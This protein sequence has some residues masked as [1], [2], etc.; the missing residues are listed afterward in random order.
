MIL[1]III[2]FILGLTGTGIT[3]F[4]FFRLRRGRKAS[5][6]ERTSEKETSSESKM[7]SLPLKL[8]AALFILV[9]T[10]GFML[11][12]GCILY[13]TYKEDLRYTGKAEGIVVEYARKLENTDDNFDYVY[14]PVVRYQSHHKTN[15]LGTG[16]VWTSRRPFKIGEQVSLR[17]DPKRTDVV[18]VESY[19]VS[20]GY[21]IG[22]IFFLFGFAISVILLLFLI[23]SHTVHDKGRKFEIM[24]QIT[25][26]ITGLLIAGVWITLAGIKTAIIMFAVSGIC[27]LILHLG[28]RR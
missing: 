11:I 17:Y 21:K 19:G 15:C 20:I 5:E 18:Y 23:L 6:S 14:A 16:N 25:A 7:L 22:I 8:Y 9:F 10:A 3:L 1:Y 24:G 13:S 26:A 12:G 28:K 2:I 27:F 4:L